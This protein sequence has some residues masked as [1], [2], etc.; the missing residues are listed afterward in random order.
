MKQACLAPDHLHLLAAAAAKLE[1]EDDCTTCA[2][3]P[4]VRITSRS[5]SASPAQPGCSPRSDQE[6]DSCQ[7]AAAAQ[8]QRLLR[9]RQTNRHAGLLI[10]RWAPWPHQR[11]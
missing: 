5:P 8:D 10:A 11:C 3:L 1:A 7:P 2:S 4:A 9:R 6:R